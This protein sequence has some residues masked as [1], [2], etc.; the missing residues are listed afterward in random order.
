[1]STEHIQ[2]TYKW[3]PQPAG[4]EGIVVVL[5]GYDASETFRH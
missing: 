3:A 2:K 4:L 1:M 5:D